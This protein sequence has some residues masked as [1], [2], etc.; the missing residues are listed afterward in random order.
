MSPLPIWHDVTSDHGILELHEDLTA[1]GP[2]LELHVVN[3]SGVA[4]AWWEDDNGTWLR[5]VDVGK[6]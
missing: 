6:A 5:I 1:P 2:A 4:V 3:E